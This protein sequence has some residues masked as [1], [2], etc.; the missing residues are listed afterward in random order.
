MLNSTVF[1]VVRCVGCLMVTGVLIVDS[2][3]K[4]FVLKERKQAV[5]N[6]KNDKNIELYTFIVNFK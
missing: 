6:C 2:F 3:L 4:G 1:V 5:I